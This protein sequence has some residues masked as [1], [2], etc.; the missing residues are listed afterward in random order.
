LTY[1]ARSFSDCGNNLEIDLETLNQYFRCWRLQPNPTKTESCVF[2]L[3]TNEAARMLDIKFADTTVQHV[4]HPKYLG[5]TLD[6][7]L[8]YNAHLTKTAKKVNARVNLVR[9][10]AGTNWGASADTLRTA[11][12]ALVYS[13]AEYCAP[14]WL[15]SVHVSKIDVQLNTTMRII[16]GTLKSTQLQWLPVLANIPPPKLRREA[17]AVR[18]LIKCRQNARSLLYEE[19][20]DVPNERLI[21]RKPVWRYDLFPETTQFSIPEAWIVKWSDD[22]PVNGELILDPNTRPPGFDLHR[23]EWVLLNRFRTNNGRCASLMHRWGLRES[24]YCDCDEV[25]QT[26]LHLVND[27]PTRSFPGGLA[28]LN[29]VCPEAVDYLS[30]LNLNL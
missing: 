25:L 15:N 26:M 14:V 16:S 21:S 27:C 1:Q 8:T 7:S 9:K 29:K 2:H 3:S 28:A 24:P 19:M 23:H 6:R 20:L 22:L 30:N 5:V 11:A 13:T 4:D 18:E 12:L 17:S 10:L